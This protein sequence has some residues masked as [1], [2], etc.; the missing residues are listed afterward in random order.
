MNSYSVGIAG[1]LP[2]T[3]DEI[4]ECLE[5]VVTG[6]KE[7]RGRSCTW[8]LAEDPT[9]VIHVVPKKT[10]KDIATMEHLSKER[11]IP[12]IHLVKTC[13]DKTYTV[14][15]AAIPATMVQAGPDWRNC[16]NSSR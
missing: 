11:L 3:A 1:S 7:C 2:E 10:D 12:T 9:H 5:R 6:S 4:A 13:D 15:D 16:R 8:S 14:S